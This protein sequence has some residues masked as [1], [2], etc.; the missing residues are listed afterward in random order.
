MKRDLIVLGYYDVFPYIGYMDTDTKIKEVLFS[1]GAKITANPNNIDIG[2]LSFTYRSTSGSNHTYSMYYK[3]SLVQSIT[4]AGGYEYYF[5][6]CDYK[7]L[8]VRIPV[9]C[10]N[11]PGTTVNGFSSDFTNVLVLDSEFIPNSSSSNT[12]SETSYSICGNILQN[13]IDGVKSTY[14]PVTNVEIILDAISNQNTNLTIVPKTNFEELLYKYL[15]KD[16]TNLPNPT[17]LDE[18]ILHS[19]ISGTSVNV[20]PETS[21]QILL[22][23]LKNI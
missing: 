9:Y 1:V 5:G 6:V 4:L 2:S 21:V 15:K 13:I 17:T 20:V 18:I 12:S 14:T 22:N 11:K 19:K 23:K 3:N 8:T 10:T 7:S 16:K